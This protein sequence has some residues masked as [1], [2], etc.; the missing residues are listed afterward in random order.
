ML[1]REEV[2]TALAQPGVT[3]LMA[4][5]TSRKDPGWEKLREL[6][7][8]GIP[9]LAIFGPGLEKPVLR[10]GGYTPSQVIAAIEDAKK[11]DGSA[12]RSSAAH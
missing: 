4:D 8:R 12:A 7:F 9:L 2:E 1:S 3:S 11:R 5:L 6:G 10:D